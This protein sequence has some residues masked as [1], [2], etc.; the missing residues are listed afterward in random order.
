MHSKNN[1]QNKDFQIAFFL[2]GSCHTPDGAYSLLC[3]LKEN[4]ELALANVKSSELRNKAKKIKAERL[5]KSNDEV[6]QLEG[7]ADLAEIDAF[8][9]H[10]AKNIAAAVDELAFINK[11]IATVDPL[12]KYKHLPDPEAHEAA[13]QEE[14]K[15][16]LIH[17][18]ENYLLTT[19]SIPVD[20]FGTMRLHPEFKTAILPS[21]QAISTLL[22]S[23]GGN[24]KLMQICSDRDFSLPLLL[25]HSDV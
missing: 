24:E 25:G 9:E 22:Q 7:Q 20:H 1:R 21:I 11:C 13:Q 23:P 5:V 3:D 18:A 14:W 15:C 2:A 17:R 16:E 4:R 8:A 12:R 6:E 19:G 10:N